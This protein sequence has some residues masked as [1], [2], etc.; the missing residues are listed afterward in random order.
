MT[1]LRKEIFADIDAERERQDRIHPK[2]VPLLIGTETQTV[3]DIQEV[4]KMHLA[5]IRERYDGDDYHDILLE[6][7]YEAF[8]AE[9]KEEKIVEFKQV[10]AVAVRIVELLE[11]GVIK[12]GENGL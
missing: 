11:Q 3:W 8:T 4:M 5:R 9:T 6:E 7:V 12:G 2:V 1:K 10:A